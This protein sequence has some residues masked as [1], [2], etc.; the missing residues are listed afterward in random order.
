MLGEGAHALLLRLPHHIVHEGEAPVAPYGLG[1]LHRLRLRLFQ[2]LRRDG[3]VIGHALEHVIE[4]PL[5]ALRIAIRVEISGPL[6]HGGEHGALRDGQ[7][8][9]RFIEIALGRHLDAP[10]ATAEIDRVEIELED[11]VLAVGALDAG[12]EHDLAQLPLEIDPASDQEILGDLL[13]DGRAALR[14][15][16]IGEVAD[17]RPDHAALIDA[18]MLVEALVLGGDE[19]LAHH[20]RDILERHPDAPP[21]LLADI[22]EALA[23]PVEHHR[24][25]AHRL[26]FQL[27]VVG[28]VVELGI[29]KGDELADIDRAAHSAMIAILLVGPDEVVEL[30]PAQGFD[31]AAHRLLIFHRRGDEIVEVDRLDVED[32]LDMSASLAEQPHHFGLVGLRI[33]HGL[34]VVWRRRHLR[35]R[36]PHGEQLDEDFVHDGEP[37]RE[38]LVP[39]NTALRKQALRRED[40]ETA[41]SEQVRGKRKRCRSRS[42]KQTQ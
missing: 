22:G 32:L 35:Q 7:V 14:A 13:G 36:K 12:G 1:D 2:L 17:Q 21:R 8:L 9:G 19:G 39:L 28:Q 5:H 42:R 38:R 24:H 6:D 20:G 11:L 34:H 31:I 18:A 41:S 33:E 16:R 29:V 26:L 30:H 4:P 3:A 15:P 40:I 10:H 25:G 37:R 23:L 27:G